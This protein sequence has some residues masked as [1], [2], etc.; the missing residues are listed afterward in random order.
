MSTATSTTQGHQ[1][2]PQP[3]QPRVV[4]GITGKVT[5]ELDNNQ[6]LGLARI[7]AH[8]DA[9]VHQPWRQLSDQVLVDIDGG[10][11]PALASCRDYREDTW[12]PVT[13]ELLTLVSDRLGRGLAPRNGES[14]REAFTRL[15][16]GSPLDR[17]VGATDGGAL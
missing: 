12:Q 7:L 1:P 14:R 8:Y 9:L 13:V 4:R 2:H 17:G 5:V 11:V 15:L 3:P 10:D 6:A 16:A